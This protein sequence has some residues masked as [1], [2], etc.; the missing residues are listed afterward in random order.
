MVATTTK[1]FTAHLNE[2]LDE[3]ENAREPI[4]VG[5]EKGNFVVLSQTDYYSM[6]ETLHQLSSA[7]NVAHLQKS[8]AQAKAGEYSTIDMDK[9]WE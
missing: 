3:A 1:E 4:L 6:V 9:L 8:V 2:W 7:A 5:N